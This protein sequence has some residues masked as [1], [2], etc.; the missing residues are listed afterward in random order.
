VEFVM[1]GNQSYSTWQADLIARYPQL[2]NQELDGRVTAPGYPNTEDGWRDLIETAIGRIASA[3]T[4][5]PGASLKIGQIKQK[6][7]T[8][9]LYVVRRDKL[10][11]ATCAAIEEAICLGKARS[12]CTCETCGAEGRLYNKSGYLFTAC[13]QHAQGQ[14]VEVRAGRENVHIVRTLRDGKLSIV[15]CRRY[16]RETDSF[17]DVTP[18]ELGLKE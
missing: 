16:V 6:F 18:S 13:D 17:V 12:A 10:P 3:V 2:F 5:V 15:S 4:A 11:E 1:S 9:R 7:G 14:A 8:L